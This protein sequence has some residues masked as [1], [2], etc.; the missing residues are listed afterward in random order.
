MTASPAISARVVAVDPRSDPRW[1]ELA[2][3]PGA[4]LF[5][6]PPWIAAICG[7][8]DLV[9]EGRV[10]RRS[11]RSLVDGLAWVRVRDARGDRLSSLPFSDRAEPFGG[12]AADWDALV[13]DALASELP[14]TVRGLDHAP[15]ARDP[16]F[17]LVG[18]AAWH[19]LPLT[20]AL[21]EVHARA[22]AGTRRNLRAAASNGVRTVA[23]ADLESVRCL[24]RLHVGLRKRKYRMLAQPLALFERI[25]SE[26]ASRDG[27]LTV[28][29]RAGRPPD[30]RR[31]LPRV[32]RR[33]L[34]QVRRV[35]RRGAAAGGRTRRS[36][37]RRSGG[38]RSAASGSSTGGCPTSTSQGSCASSA[39]GAA[40]SG[41]S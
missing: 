13:R 39:S 24:H 23:A 36:T 10:L 16:R 4:S 38:P 41:A 33:P 21:E 18:E 8:Y 40:W 7:T 17:R 29:A 3:T 19:G 1:G 5:T 34:L 20:G 12:D 2:A 9:P 27:V 6:S 26:F 11:G 25:W 32:E 14:L 31:P 37:G 35:D 22:S 28:L 15:V 30:R